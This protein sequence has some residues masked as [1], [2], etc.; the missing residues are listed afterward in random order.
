M[1][2]KIIIIIIIVYTVQTDADNDDDDD[3]HIFEVHFHNKENHQPNW[4]SVGDFETP[5]LNKI[6]AD[7]S[8]DIAKINIVDQFRDQVLI[9][10]S[11]EVQSSHQ[12]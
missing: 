10:K 6:A 9:L 3:L 4:A 11:F 12:D 5:Q 1:A 7:I 8:N 2:K